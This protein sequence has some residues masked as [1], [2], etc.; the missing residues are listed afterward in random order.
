METIFFIE[1]HYKSYGFEPQRELFLKSK[2]E[3]MEIKK[4]PSWNNTNN[5]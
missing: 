2:C 3:T 5:I 1:K 4:R